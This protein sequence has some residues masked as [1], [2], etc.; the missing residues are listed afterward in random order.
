V[1]WNS[2]LLGQ[3]SDKIHTNYFPRVFINAKEYKEEEPCQI[4]FK[5]IANVTIGEKSFAIQQ[6][7]NV[8]SRDV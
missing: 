7:T 2:G 5:K 6:Y 1:K 8:S 3:V 4:S